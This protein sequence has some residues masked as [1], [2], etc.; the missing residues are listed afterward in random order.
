MD[1]ETVEQRRRRAFVGL[2]AFVERDDA[3]PADLLR[4]ASVPAKRAALALLS[5]SAIARTSTPPSVCAIRPVSAIGRPARNVAAR[6]RPP[7]RRSSAMLGGAR[8]IGV[9]TGR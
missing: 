4:R 1:S 2:I 5:R 3:D 9:S 6:S 7:S 8:R